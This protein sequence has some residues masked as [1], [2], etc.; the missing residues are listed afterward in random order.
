MNRIDVYKLIDGEREYQ[1]L[2]WGKVFD[3]TNTLEDW[4]AY[5]IQ[6]IALADSNEVALNKTES[7]ENI[8]KVAAL[9]V[10]CMEQN[11]TPARNLE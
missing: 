8:R 3:D 1:N 7:L 6:Y 4:I 10:A 5:I 2:R 11:D 9:C